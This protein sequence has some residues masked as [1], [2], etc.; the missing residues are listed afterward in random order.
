MENGIFKIDHKID[1]EAGGHLPFLSLSYSTFGHYIKGHSK[2][3]WVF[4]ALTANQNPLEWW[5]GLFGQKDFFSPEDFFIIC[6]NVPGSCYGST[7]PVSQDLPDRYK[8]E[9]FP[10]LTVRDI[11]AACKRLQNHLGIDKV[12]IVIGGSFGGYQALEFAY[13]NP[14]V[15]NAILISTAAIETP[16]NIAIHETQRQALRADKNFQHGQ[17]DA[18]R[19][20]EAAR[21]IGMLSYRS[22]HSFITFQPRETDQI[23]DF[24]VSGYIRYQGEKLRKRFSPWAYYHLTRILDTHDLGRKRGGLAT[25]LTNIQARCLLIGIEGDILAPPSAMRK[26]CE[27]MPYAQFKLIESDFGHDGFLIETQKI[28]ELISSWL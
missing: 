19:G 25:A 18:F 26:M 5:P 4:H 10:L 2:V 6:V 16:W 12:H 11:T 23:D 14:D 17:D 24:R 8:M 15:E 9:F 20:L 21:G 13:D 1:L 28:A 27:C 7:G 3:V 22:A